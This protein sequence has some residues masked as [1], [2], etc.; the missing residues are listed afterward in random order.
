MIDSA[1][2]PPIGEGEWVA[3]FVLQR[4]HVRSDQTVKPDA[5]MPPP[6]LELSVT[7]HLSSTESEIWSVAQAVAT[8]RHRT[9]Y[10]WADVTAK[11]CVRRQLSVIAAP[12]EGNPNHA[13]VA[14]WP[15]DKAHQKNIAQ[16]IAAAAQFV[17]VPSV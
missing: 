12:V 11:E 13:N 15:A 2:V 10:G 17:R 1:N 9:L 6:N 14:G 3:R 4:S 7:R 8:A 16:Q 5:F